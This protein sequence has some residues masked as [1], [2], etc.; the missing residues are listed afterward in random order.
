M[1]KR[2]IIV[3]GVLAALALAGCGSSTSAV[4]TVDTPAFLSTTAQPG[5]VI[6][7]VRTPD[8]FAAGHLQNAV[9]I[10][11]EDPDFA[12]EIESLDKAATYAVYCRSGRRSAVATDVMGAAGFTSVFNLSGGL[13][14]L[15]ASGAVVVTQ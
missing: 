1:M 13:E 5:V 3:A 10:N 8:E 7:D 6:V 12:E 2:F 15:A 11:V 9:N 14:D 4:Q